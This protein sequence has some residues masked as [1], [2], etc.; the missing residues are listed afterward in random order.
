MSKLISWDDQHCFLTVLQEGSLSAAARKLGV[1]QPTV[2]TRIARLE[3]AVGATLFTR[4]INGLIPTDHARDLFQSVHSM[5][6]ASDEFVRRASAPVGEIAGTVRLSM[7][8]AMG[9]EIVPFML[10]RARDDHPALQIELELSNRPADLLQREVDIAVRTTPPKQD[11][12]VA[13]KVA[14]IPLCYFASHG[15]I[16]RH[17]EPQTLADLKSH[18]IIGPDRNQSDLKLAKRIGLDLDI[19]PAIRTDS[20]PAQI[21]ATVAGLGIGIMQMPI[22]R[23]YPDLKQILTS[24]TVYRMDTWIVTHED[25]RNIPKIRYVFDTL[26]TAF[27][28]L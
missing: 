17:G 26:V 28:D 9:T 24:Q 13:H 27:M 25:L 19:R 2:R 20:H 21:A 1:S 5:A 11:A 16:A 8:E 6:L 7:P 15:Y 12:L 10:A 4:S 23:K 22:G 18:T 3:E 14:S